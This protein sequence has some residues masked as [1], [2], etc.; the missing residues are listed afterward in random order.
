MIMLDVIALPACSHLSIWPLNANFG[1]ALIFL[2][3]S[4]QFFMRNP[5]IPLSIKSIQS[6]G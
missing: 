6:K 4:I 5:K 3:E 1:E 2:A